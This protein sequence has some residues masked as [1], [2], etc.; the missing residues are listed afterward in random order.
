[1]THYSTP[2]ATPDPVLSWTALHLSSPRFPTFFR[3]FKAFTYLHTAHYF[4]FVFPPST[5]LNLLFF[6]PLPIFQSPLPNPSLSLYGL[7][8][9][10]MYALDSPLLPHRPHNPD[11]CNLFSPPSFCSPLIPST[12]QYF[13]RFNPSFI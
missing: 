2:A 12:S 9:I 13:S 7:P 4:P 8:H 3:L 1:M 11:F 6:C 5:G 10:A